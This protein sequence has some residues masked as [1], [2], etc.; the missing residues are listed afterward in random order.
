ML[1]GDESYRDLF[2]L[3]LSPVAWSR[4]AREAARVLRERR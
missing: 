2:R 1:T 4:L 3:L